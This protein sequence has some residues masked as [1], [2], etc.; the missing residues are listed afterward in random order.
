VPALGRS[1]VLV[2]AVLVATVAAFWPTV[3]SLVVHW[4]DTVSLSYTHGYAIVA[5]CAWLLWRARGRIA[6]LPP[7]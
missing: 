2:C 6:A 1:F 5:V 4:E 3:A 7:P